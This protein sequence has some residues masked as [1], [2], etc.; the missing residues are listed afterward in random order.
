MKNRRKI[1]RRLAAFLLCAVIA[2]CA[3]PWQKLP[4]RTSAESASITESKQTIKMMEEELELLKNSSEAASSAYED[5]VKA[6]DAAELDIARAYDAKEALDKK[7]TALEKE[8][9]SY[10]SLLAIY[11]EQISATNEQIAEKEAEIDSRYHEFLDRIRINYEDSFTSYLSIILESDSFADFLYHVDM[12]ASLLD[13]DKR[14]LA[15]LDLAKKDLES[16][17]ANYQTMQYKAQET[18]NSLSERMPELEAERQRNT[19]LLEEL[20]TKLLE[21]KNKKDATEAEK[22]KLDEQLRL[23]E[24]R[25]A[26][27]EAALEQKIREEQKRLEA[28]RRAREEAE[29][30]AREEAERLRREEEERKR[31]EEEKRKQEEA[32]QQ[33][34][35]N[36][37][38]PPVTEAPVKEDP[39]P[40][41]NTP[42]KEDP[43]DNG[44]Y[45][46]PVDTRYSVISSPYGYRTSPL[47]GRS[48]LH[49]G[50]DIPAPYGSNIY[51]SRTGTVIIADWHYSYGNYVVIDHGDGVSTLYAH[52]SKLLVKAGDVVAQGD[53]IALCGSTGDSQGNHCHF[54]VRIDGVTTQPL[55]YVKQP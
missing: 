20:N 12:V 9:D 4:L 11:N 52:N 35:Q 27:E 7:I 18:L 43:V 39:V 21:L 23:Q 15:S 41:T 22:E 24:E 53:V 47:S 51:A 55:N 29:R 38:D 46:W 1:L 25:F 33:G 32:A 16:L 6:Y 44:T 2:V 5:A 42:P 50:I 30:K 28:E 3:V 19:E 26:A 8:I 17:E 37:N 13:Y 45:I 48:E 54:C 10:R 36:Q 34:G 49:N 40:P 31:L 14:V